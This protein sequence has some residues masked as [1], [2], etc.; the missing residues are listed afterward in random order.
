[1]HACIPC[2]HEWQ[3]N[4]AGVTWLLSSA[5]THMKGLPKCELLSLFKNIKG[6][7]HTE[8]FPLHRGRNRSPHLPVAAFV[9]S[10]LLVSCRD[11]SEPVSSVHM[12]ISA[13]RSRTSLF[14]FHV[15]T[16]FLILGPSNNV[17]HPASL[18]G[19]FLS[20]QTLQSL[21]SWIIKII[22]HKRRQR[23]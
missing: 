21:P 16:G 8:A 6:F 3:T 2:S 11:G 5:P 15:D 13:R 9:S 7:H 19:D 22:K 4:K 23:G 12:I 10:A 14:V 20:C 18:L 1:M 17:N